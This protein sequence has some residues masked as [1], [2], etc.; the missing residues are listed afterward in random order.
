MPEERTELPY[1][2]SGGIQVRSRDRNEASPRSAWGPKVS[3]DGRLFTRL[4]KPRSGGQWNGRTR[5]PV[6][7]PGS[8][9]RFVK[10]RESLPVKITTGQGPLDPPT[11]RD[12]YPNPSVCVST[13]SALRASLQTFWTPRRPPMFLPAKRD[14]RRTPQVGRGQQTT[15]RRDRGATTDNL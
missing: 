6:P 7:V 13:G 3:V 2:S 5:H 4:F 11:T 10:R 1:P 14:G 9:P 15:L 12:R 8:S